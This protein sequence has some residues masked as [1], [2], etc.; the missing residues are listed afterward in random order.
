MGKKLYECYTENINFETVRGF[1]TDNVEMIFRWGLTGK[2]FPQSKFISFGFNPDSRG[3]LNL[4]KVTKSYG[5]F[6]GT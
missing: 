5:H 6:S 1:M 2:I 3:G 4:K